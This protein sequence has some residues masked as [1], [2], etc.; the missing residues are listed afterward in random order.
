ML[1]PPSLDSKFDIELPSELPCPIFNSYSPQSPAVCF[2]S[3]T[4][5]TLLSYHAQRVC[6]VS[7]LILSSWWWCESWEAVMRDLGRMMIRAAGALFFWSR[8]TVQ[9]T[10]VRAAAALRCAQRPASIKRAIHL[11]GAVT[12]TPHLFLLPVCLTGGCTGQPELRSCQPLCN[13][14]EWRISL[15]NE[16]YSDNGYTSINKR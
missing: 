7:R 8:I 16:F 10:C 2:S 1:V 9:Q 3:T 12:P 14:D 11:S 5:F 6:L 13:W 15:L 4:Q